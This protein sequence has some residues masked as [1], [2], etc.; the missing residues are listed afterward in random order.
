MIAE[1]F[2]PHQAT[3]P[4]MMDHPMF[5]EVYHQISGQPRQ[6]SGF[7]PNPFVR[8]SVETYGPSA[9]LPAHGLQAWTTDRLGNGHTTTSTIGDVDACPVYGD[10]GG[11]SPDAADE[12]ADPRRT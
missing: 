2:H 10:A 5:P 7:H 3:D 12:T 9:R 4:V 11:H 8:D 1:P 6:A